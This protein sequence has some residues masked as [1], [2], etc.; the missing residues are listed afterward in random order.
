MLVIAA[1]GPVVAVATFYAAINQMFIAMGRTFAATLVG[2]LFVPAF[3]V[4]VPMV[5]RLG[6]FGLAAIEMFV[7]SF[8]LLLLILIGGARA[9]AFR[10]GVTTSA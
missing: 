10:P 5:S 7:N 3:F 1:F 8:A 9:K 2:C 6:V 4:A